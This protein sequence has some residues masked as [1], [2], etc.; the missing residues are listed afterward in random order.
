MD[1]KQIVDMLFERS[2][3]AL[4]EVSDKYGALCT[5][6]MRRV[7][8]NVSDI[9]ECSNDVLLAVWNSI[10]P[11]RPENLAAYLCT[12]SRNAALNRLKYNNRD[13][14]NDKLTVMFSE[15][16]ESFEAFE[17]NMNFVFERERL[18]R[19]INDFLNSLDGQTRVLFIRR[20]IFFES[21]SELSQRF[22]V[23]ENF[24][25]VKLHRA[26]KKLRNILEKEDFRI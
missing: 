8:D 5:S 21:P 15:L 10:P 12:L 20:Y 24:I 7:L 16:D 9:E 2:E 19:V 22:D 17:E 4:K 23:T 6:V 11:K 14:R 26:R 1:D 13:K 18:R 25:N 3:Y